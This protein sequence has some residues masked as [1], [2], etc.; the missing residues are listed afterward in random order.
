LKKVITSKR[1]K[2]EKT[3]A[4]TQTPPTSWWHIPEVRDR[5]NSMISGDLKTDPQEYVCKKYFAD[6][7]SLKLL[8]LAC[9]TGSREIRWAELK[10]FIQIDA[11]DISKPR[12]EYAKKQAENK[13]LN[14]IINFEISDVFKISMGTD[15]YDVVATE[16]ALHHFSPLETILLKIENCLKPDGYFVVNDFVGPTRFQWT[17][18]QL[19]VVNGLLALLPIDYKR[20]WDNVTIKQ[21]VYKPSILSMILNDP[22]E[23]IE[24]SKIILQL[25]KIFD[26][27]EIKEYGGTILNPLFSRI[28]HNFISE[29]DEAKDFLKLCFKVE[30]LLLA[31]KDI[32]SDY[33]LAICKKKDGKELI[34]R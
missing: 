21:K 2:V 31:K 6:K 20:E 24:S 9:G 10:K 3:W 5:W 1:Q 11:Y 14:K 30:D 25:N 15:K 27:I 32:Q 23:A 22:S 19:A 34:P 16:G 28:A 7:Q 33:V 13:G 4:S 18:R 8:S 12:I 26:V 29:K 17:K